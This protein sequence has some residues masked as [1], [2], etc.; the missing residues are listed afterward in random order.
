MH[1]KP[2]LIIGDMDSIKGNPSGILMERHKPDKDLTDGQLG[3][4]VLLN[5]IKPS[6]ITILGARGGRADHEFYNYFL[7]SYATHE[8][9]IVLYGGDSLVECLSKGQHVRPSAKG[10]IVSLS[11][12]MGDVHIEYSKGLKYEI[13][14]ATYGV[15]GVAPISNVA[16]GK[17]FELSIKQGKA[18]VFYI[19]EHKAKYNLLQLRKS[20]GW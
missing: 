18:L 16:L 20:Q 19:D 5:E 7:L 8:T 11:P 14:N 17:Q 15:S 10:S 1:C 12:F 9:R 13:D 2:D 4:N 3:L 6:K